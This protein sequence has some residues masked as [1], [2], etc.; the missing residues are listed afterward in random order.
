M[1]YVLLCPLLS[2]LDGAKHQTKISLQR[3]PLPLA[4]FL[5]KCL[6]IFFLSDFVFLEEN[7]ICPLLR[8]CCYLHI[9]IAKQPPFP[10]TQ[11]VSDVDMTLL[12]AYSFFSAADLR[13]L[14]CGISYKCLTGMPTVETQE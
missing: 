1:L 9:Y 2:V 12:E 8:D 3:K 10:R 13:Q 6:A 5:S 7:I 14:A 4:T 11:P